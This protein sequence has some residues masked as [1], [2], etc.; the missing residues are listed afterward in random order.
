[1]KTIKIFATLGI[2]SLVLFSCKN[3]TN[4]DEEKFM[5]EAWLDEIE[6]NQN[7]AWNADSVTNNGVEKLQQTLNEF[8]TNTLKDYHQ[9]ANHLIEINNYIIDNCTMKGEAHENLHIWLYPLLE[10]VKLLKEAKTTVEA[11]EIRVSIECS[12]QKYATYFQ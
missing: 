3:Q 4:T 12:V 1:M 10:K 5:N 9:L 2:L 8:S 7:E 11:E 6:L